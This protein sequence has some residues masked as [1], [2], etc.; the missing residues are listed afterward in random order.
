MKQFPTVPPSAMISST[1]SGLPGGT[2]PSFA[3]TASSR[4]PGAVKVYGPS[5]RALTVAT[6]AV[7]VME[8]VASSQFALPTA[9]A[10]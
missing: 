8:R 9:H 3:S 10:K 2:V 7:T 5:G 4:N 1:R 6:G